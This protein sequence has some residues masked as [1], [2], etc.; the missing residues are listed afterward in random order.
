MQATV[1]C[2]LY[3][4]FNE[5]EQCSYCG[6]RGVTIFGFNWNMQGGVYPYCLSQV[7]AD[8]EAADKAHAI[9]AHAIITHERNKG[10]RMLQEAQ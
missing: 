3:S 6:E 5:N 9:I 8:K 7:A 10:W 4:Q 2:F 1:P